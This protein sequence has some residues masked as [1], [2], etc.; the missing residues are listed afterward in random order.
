MLTRFL[1]LGAL[2]LVPAVAAR[3]APGDVNAQSFY[4]DARDLSAKG[5]KAMF[6]KRARPAMAA[7]KDAG[8]RVRDENEAAKSRGAPLYCVSEAQRKKGM[9]PQMIVDM[10]G[11][12]PEAQRK[13][14][15]LVQAWRTALVREYPCT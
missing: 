11:R 1:V 9:S 5:M 10:L 8:E 15:T 14:A 2:V 3:A 4:L 13:R 12:V 7:M 6:D